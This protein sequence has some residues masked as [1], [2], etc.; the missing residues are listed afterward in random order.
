MTLVRGPLS[1]MFMIDSV[2]IEN[3]KNFLKKTFLQVSSF[4]DS[5]YYL[6]SNC[7]TGKWN[8]FKGSIGFN[9]Y[10]QIYRHFLKYI[11]FENSSA[12]QN[13]CFEKI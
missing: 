11:G 9:L 8:Y 4:Q 3:S 10:F 7:T 12:F 1:E 2:W 6:E 5:M 13:E